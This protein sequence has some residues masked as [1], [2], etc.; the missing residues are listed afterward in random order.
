[1]WLAVHL[2]GIARTFFLREFSVKQVN[3]RNVE[4]LKQLVIK[5]T[6]EQA[7]KPAEAQGKPCIPSGLKV[8]MVFCKYG[9]STH[10]N[11][12]TDSMETNFEDGLLAMYKAK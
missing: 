3:Y 4:D 11:I 8:L 1:M 9:N 6:K 7:A 12:S 10:L 2:S 5:A